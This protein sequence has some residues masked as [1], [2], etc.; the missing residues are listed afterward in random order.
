MGSLVACPCGHGVEDH[1]K[2]GCPGTAR[3]R[4]NCPRTSQMA[5]D[6]AVAAVRSTFNDD[7]AERE[8]ADRNFRR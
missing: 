8:A 1:T 3:Q 4:C 2:G 7:R 5:L 6:A